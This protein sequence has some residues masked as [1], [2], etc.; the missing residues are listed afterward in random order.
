MEIT[1]LLKNDAVRVTFCS[2]KNCV[3]SGNDLFS[4]SFRPKADVALIFN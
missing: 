4:R 3:M 2:F 1:A